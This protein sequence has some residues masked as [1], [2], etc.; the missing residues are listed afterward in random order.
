MGY[1]GLPGVTK[2]TGVSR[3][4]KKKRRITRD[5][6]GIKGVT[7]GYKALAGFIMV[8]GGY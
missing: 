3:G 5:Y 2:V 1:K 4:Y 7:G 6:R 8:I